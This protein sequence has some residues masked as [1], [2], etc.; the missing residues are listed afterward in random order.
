MLIGSADARGGI[1]PAG[2]VERTA[3]SPGALG[4]RLVLASSIIALLCVCAWRPVVG[5]AATVPG[6]SL[7]AAGTGLVFVPTMRAPAAP[8]PLPAARFDVAEPG[9]DPV[10]V[11]ARIDP[12]SGLRE[13]TLTRGDFDALEAPALRVTLSRGTEAGAAPTLFVLLARRAATGPTIDR[14]ALSVLRT[15]A[16]GQIDT[17]FGAVEILEVTFGGPT[18]RTCAG[19]VTRGAAFRLDGWSC[20]PLGRP[21]ELQALTCTLDALRFLDLGDPETTTTFAGAASARSCPP[22]S[23]VAEA[24]DGAGSSAKRSRNKK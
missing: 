9:L 18:P 8:P 24:S 21:P 20:A 12:R 16:R 14:P 7:A 19:F 15:G 6:M 22:A 4:L 2:L 23:Q 10:R 17:K 1:A 11:S 3:L 13:D 5:P